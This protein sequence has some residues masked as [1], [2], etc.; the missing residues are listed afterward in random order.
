MHGDQSTQKYMA[1]MMR[2]VKMMVVSWASFWNNTWWGCWPRLP[3]LI[4]FENSCLDIDTDPHSVWRQPL[5]CLT[6]PGTPDTPTH[7]PGLLGWAPPGLRIPPTAEGWKVTSHTLPPPP[8]QHQAPLSQGQSAIACCVRLSRV[9][10]GEVTRETCKHRHV[11]VR[12]NFSSY[13]FPRLLP[14][15]GKLISLWGCRAL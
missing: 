4:Y 8:V 11:G 9:R 5:A 7:S 1:Q 15:V 2:W 12:L 6:L 13:L 10:S 14:L 3:P